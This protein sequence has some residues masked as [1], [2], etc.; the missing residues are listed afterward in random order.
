MF[1][2]IITSAD[3]T[4][5]EGTCTEA[6]AASLLARAVRLGYRVT[7]TRSGGSVIVRDIPSVAGCVPRRRMVT[8]EPAVPCGTLTATVR[9]DLAAVDKARAPYLRDG[10]ICAGFY[11]VPPT[12][13][14][15][16]IGRALVTVSDAKGERSPVV[17]S[18][19]ARLAML[20]A[21][22]QTRTSKPRG[23]YRDP[24]HIGPWRKGGC[25]YDRSSAASCSC[26]G[27]SAWAEDRDGARRKAR[28][29]RESVTAVFIQSLARVTSPANS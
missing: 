9:R 8:L 2:E 5:T 20:A 22:H 17:V 21:D 24:G 7:A 1:R 14:A 25:M 11:T 15:R 19:V 28:E 13:T 4:V 10:R 23:Y 16:L 3:G 29:H 26:R 12:A 6:H 27:F 18:L